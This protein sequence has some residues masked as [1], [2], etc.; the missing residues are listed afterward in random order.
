MPTFI[1]PRRGIFFAGILLI[2]VGA[3]LSIG[4]AHYLVSPSRPGEPDQLFV[5]PQGTTLRE[6]AEGLEGAGIISNHSLLLLWCRMAGCGADIKAG[7]YRL[8]SS[9][10]PLAVLDMLNKG[11]VIA[12]SV[13]IPEGFTIGQIAAELDK[14]GL[15]AEEEFLALATDPRMPARYGLLSPNLEGY[16]Y[17]DTY[18]FSKG[19]PV[20]AV[21]DVM[22]KRFFEKITPLKPRIEASGM[23]LEDIVTMASIVEKETGKEEE[24]PLIAS[25]FLNRLKKGMRLESDPTVIYGIEDFDGNLTRKDLAHSGPYNTYVIR[26]LPPGPIASPGEAAIRAVLF[27]AQTD[28]LYFV[29]KNDGSHQF[30]RTLT[31]HNRAVNAFQKKGRGKK[32]ETS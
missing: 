5:V 15:A 29:S 2:A 22:V 17:P 27:P 20:A 10:A 26:G 16:L 1:T 13:T 25:V 4:F 7:E 12:H 18:R 9:M 11:T 32:G 21:I 3:L 14:K 24:R 23:A 6:V 30:S 8:S 28:Y 31:E 19:Q